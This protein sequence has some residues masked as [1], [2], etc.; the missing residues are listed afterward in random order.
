MRELHHRPPGGK[1]G[2]PSSA[3]LCLRRFIDAAHALDAAWHP[4]LDRP[5]YPRYLPSF[6]TFVSD[7]VDWRD[8]VE[9]RAAVAESDLKPLDL[10][11]PA[12]VRAWLTDLRAQVD[13]AM[14]AGEDATRPLSRR[15][16]GR[17]MARRSLLEAR[18][19]L[20][21]LLEMAERGATNPASG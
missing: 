16:L 17:P 20:Q 2:D 21:Q 12:A 6:D 3:R 19:A 11:D 10:G 15:A 9:E 5:T 13:D 14:A 7:L 4:D 18:H 8:E 1:G